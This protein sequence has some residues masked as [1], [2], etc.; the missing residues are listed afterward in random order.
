MLSVIIESVHK[1][2]QNRAY[3][4]EELC[5][6]PFILGD[7]PFN[8]IIRNWNKG[9]FSKSWRNYSL[10]R[11]VKYLHFKIYELFSQVHPVRLLVISCLLF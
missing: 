6:E 5:S 3:E 1:M 2:P 11:K 10:G 8:L 9:F 4:L 7:V